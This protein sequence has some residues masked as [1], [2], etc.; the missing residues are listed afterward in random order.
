LAS[1]KRF[2]ASKYM[3]GRFA[4]MAAGFP[5]LILPGKVSAIAFFLN[6]GPHGH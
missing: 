6:A 3:G 1:R 5:F 2:S 4:G